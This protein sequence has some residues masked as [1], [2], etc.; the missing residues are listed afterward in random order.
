L[1]DNTR[2]YLM[3]AFGAQ[4]HALGLTTED[5]PCP[6]TLRSIALAGM[7]DWD[8]GSRELVWMTDPATLSLLPIR[9]SRP[10]EPWPTSR[11]T[12]LGDAI[13]SMTPYP[14]IGANVALRDAAL[15]SRQLA[16]ASRGEIALLDAVAEYERAMLRYGFA[17]V[18]S[19]LEA[20]KASLNTGAIGRAVMRSALRGIDRIPTLKHWFGMAMTAE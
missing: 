13:H 16:R 9:T 5:A 2:S 18:R 17:A 4:R 7:A 11:I 14:G 19:S 12:L 10:V 1:F 3:W 8:P 15:L 6:E 20:M